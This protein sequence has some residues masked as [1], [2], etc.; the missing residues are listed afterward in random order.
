[1]GQ[2]LFLTILVIFFK[3]LIKKFI[4]ENTWLK[5]LA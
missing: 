5:F 4:L 3:L 2:N 1:M